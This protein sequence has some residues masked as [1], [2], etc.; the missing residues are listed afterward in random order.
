MNAA[1]GM[2]AMQEETISRLTNQIGSSTD[3]ER[4]MRTT[5]QE[6]GLAL[7]ASRSFIQIGMNTST[8]EEGVP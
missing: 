1:N 2:H 3:F 6:L 8:N 5:V 4:I 7:G